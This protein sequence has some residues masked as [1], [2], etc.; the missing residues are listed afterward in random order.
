D[1]ALLPA[2]RADGAVRACPSGAISIVD[3]SS[4]DGGDL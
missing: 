3:E 4:G 1:G 2:E